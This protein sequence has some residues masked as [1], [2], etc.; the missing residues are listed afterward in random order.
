MNPNSFG[1]FGAFKEIAI[2]QTQSSG[3]LKGIAKSHSLREFTLKPF[4]F[5]G[6]I[7]P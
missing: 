2:L 5:K 4:V 7:E 6:F 1:D 3:F